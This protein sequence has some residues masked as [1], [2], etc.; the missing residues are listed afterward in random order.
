V[1]QKKEE[2]GVQGAEKG[3]VCEKLGGGEGTD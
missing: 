2:G 1:G 3:M